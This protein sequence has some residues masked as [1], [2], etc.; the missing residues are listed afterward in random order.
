MWRWIPVQYDIKNVW[1]EARHVPLLSRDPRPARPLRERR[2]FPARPRT[3]R[4]TCCVLPGTGPE[5]PGESRTWESGCHD[6]PAP[7]VRSAVGAQS[8]RI[9]SRRTA[10]P[11]AIAR[12]HR[13]YGPD[14][15]EAL[16]VVTEKRC[17]VAPH[18]V[19]GDI[20][21]LASRDAL[22]TTSPP[23]LD[24]TTPPYDPCRRM[25]REGSRGAIDSD[26]SVFHAYS[27]QIYSS[28]SQ[29]RGFKEVT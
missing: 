13:R 14:V 23:I 19:A 27:T 17:V 2:G 8:E 20:F 15:E 4:G 5:I 26:G 1:P 25:V 16:L 29:Q 12:R 18:E 9:D 3:S 28:Q 10:T 21:G 7:A 22:D 24:T 6:A 11:A